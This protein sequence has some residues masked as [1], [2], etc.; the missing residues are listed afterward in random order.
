ME[1]NKTSS[2]NT[3][4][5]PNKGQLTPIPISPRI[6]SN[7]SKAFKDKDFRNL[8]T[9]RP[10]TS[11]TNLVRSNPIPSN[12]VQMPLQLKAQSKVD[13]SKLLKDVKEIKDNLE[14]NMDSDFVS[15]KLPS[16]S[17][18]RMPSKSEIKSYS[19]V[20]PPNSVSNS[21]KVIKPPDKVKVIYPEVKDVKDIKTPIQDIKEVKDDKS[22]VQEI[23]EIKSAKEVK[24]PVQETKEVKSSVQEI[25]EVKT[26]VQEI[27][28]VKSQP[29]ESKSTKD[30]KPP[31]QDI[32]S[33]KETNIQEPKLPNLSKS[34]SK[35][36][37]KPIQNPQPKRDRSPIRQ[38]ANPKMTVVERVTETVNKNISNIKE[39]SEEPKE[40]KKPKELIPIKDRPFSPKDPTEI[41]IHGVVM[42]RDEIRPIDTNDDIT[43]FDTLAAID[44]VTIIN[45]DDLDPL[46][47]INVIPNNTEIL[48]QEQL[49]QERLREEQLIQEQRL[50]QEQLNQERI[51]I[52]QIA[53]ER[54]RQEQLNQ[55]RLRQEQ[56]NQE[57]LRQEQLNQ[58]RLRQEQLVQDRLRQEQLAQERLRQEQLRQNQQPQP[59][60]N[61]SNQSRQIFD[62]EP[63]D[64]IIHQKLP[65]LPK[66]NVPDYST[67]TNLEKAHYRAQFTTQFGI[68]RNNWPNY[69]I[70]DIDPNSSLEEIHAQYDV[71]R[72]HLQITYDVNQYKMYLAFFWMAIELVL[73]NILGLKV[74]GFC[75]SQLMS[76]QHYHHILMELGEEN[77]QASSEGIGGYRSSWSPI[78][79]LLYVTLV[80]AVVFILLKMASNYFS[81]ETQQAIM[82]FINGLLSGNPMNANE[83]LLG[84][85]PNTHGPGALPTQQNMF[86]GFDLGNLGNIGNLITT[87]APM[88]GLN[89]LGGTRAPVQPQPINQQAAPNVQSFAPAWVED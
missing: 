41:K 3:P 20:K 24:S 11:P 16:K 28:E 75:I 43:E 74:G 57:R 31:I 39:K 30:I 14:M 33:S 80:N 32:K 85:A 18:I 66:I 61:Q 67:L 79:N 15:E 52:E 58:E 22:A 88:L 35:S 7:N 42:N 40:I 45:V 12:T 86:A 21:A 87:F 50:R 8:N 49:A 51:R 55:E 34:N 81:A 68:L 71:Y 47:E 5:S 38:A 73:T 53:Q 63:I 48:R 82:N 17:E 13:P 70:P 27:K 69:H 36:N 54:S 56:L 59:R 6:N 37:P 64:N 62:D 1:D 26:P 76:M 46:D 65:T 23:K 77:Y 78:T 9:S 4:S 2:T 83:V 10:S 60:S 25:K 72:K 89:G 44:T 19:E 29:Q 84:Q